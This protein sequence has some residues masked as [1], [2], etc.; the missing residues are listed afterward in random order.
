MLRELSY[1]PHGEAIDLDL[2]LNRIERSGGIV[3]P[4]NVNYE[5][6]IAESK[7][8]VR[9]KER[10]YEFL[11][12]KKDYDCNQKPCCLAVSP[13]RKDRVADV[14][15]PEWIQIRIYS[16]SKGGV[17][18]GNLYGPGSSEFGKY[19][20][21]NPAESCNPGMLAVGATHDGSSLADYNSR[22][23]IP[24]GCK[25]DPSI[26]KPDI[27]SLSNQNSWTMMR[28]TPTPSMTFPGTSAAPH[29]AGLAATFPG[30][31]ASA[32]HVAGLAAL[33]KQA[34]PD[35]GPVEIADYLRENAIRVPVGSKENHD[36]GYG[37][38]ALPEPPMTPDP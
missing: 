32:P 2:F 30:T 3:R 1:N 4:V 5:D 14:D 28:S 20:I 21:G 34:F 29:V 8:D 10:L 9:G 27:V 7:R 38:A 11:E 13:V 25:S 23:P 15:M 33:V 6:S 16:E 17:S 35:M 18:L 19:S 37:R 26:I 12:I 31:S 24:V 22:G 36:W